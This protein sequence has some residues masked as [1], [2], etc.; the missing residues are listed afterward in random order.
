MPDI[1]IIHKEISTINKITKIFIK[2]DIGC[3]TAQNCRDGLRALENNYQIDLILVDGDM[4][5]RQQLK[6]LEFL[7]KRPRFYF[8]P[9]VSICNNCSGDKIR[10]LVNSGVFDIISSAI[11]M[12]EKVLMDRVEK[13]LK[14]SKPK[15][16][17]IEENDLLAG[18]FIYI[19]DLSGFKGV[20]SSD[21]DG[22]FETIKNDNI[23]AVVMDI[24]FTRKHGLGT[25]ADIKKNIEG[26]P[27]I[28]LA[29]QDIR[30]RERNAVL[31]S[32]ADGY[33]TKPFKNIEYAN[34][35]RS[36][37]IHDKGKNKRP[38]PV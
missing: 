35:V 23:S 38:T 32:G 28:L 6:M 24:N 27:V 16:L 19:S 34:L 21:L 1:L 10:K 8:I 7:Q 9:V 37:L 17:F 5:L 4:E 25:I 29:T 2:H 31:R 33:L 36:L 14:H 26:G 18:H 15:I 11:I 20:G 30:P 22:A 13:A 3:V 12:D